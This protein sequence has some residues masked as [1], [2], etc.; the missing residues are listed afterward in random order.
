[1]Q[2]FS[3]FV[4]YSSHYQVG[5]NISNN[6]RQVN[7]HFVHPL[8][9]YILLLEWRVVCW[10]IKSSGCRIDEQSMKTTGYMVKRM[11]SS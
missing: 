9:L 11:F 4:L 10:P 3:Y 2:T 7:R 8:H 6:I 5:N 1:M